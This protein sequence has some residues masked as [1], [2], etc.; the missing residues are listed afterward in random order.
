VRGYQCI[1]EQC[2]DEKERKNTNAKP[3][4]KIEKKT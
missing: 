3:E 4:E 2:I 1:E